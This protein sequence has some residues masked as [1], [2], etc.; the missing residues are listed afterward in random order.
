MSA[1]SNL[2]Q[3]STDDLLAEIVRRRNAEQ[4]DSPVQFCE[5]CTNFVPDPKSPD[6]YNPCSKGHKMQFKIPEGYDFDNY[7]FYR[8]VCADRAHLVDVAAIATKKQHKAR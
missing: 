2:K 5:S 1:E 7:G 4:L 6:T 8:R 3:F